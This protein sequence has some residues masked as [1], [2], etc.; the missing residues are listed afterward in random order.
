MQRSR[1]G[2]AAGRPANRSGTVSS[3]RHPGARRVVRTAIGRFAA[4]A[5]PAVDRN[6]EY[7]GALSSNMRVALLL[8]SALIAS[9]AGREVA[10]TIDD[11]PR[12]G[13]HGPS[14]LAGIRAMTERLLKPFHDQ[15]IPL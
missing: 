9:A 6:K 13:D 12:G 4:P 11:L 3:R 1:P 8:L 15:K 2:D 7:L 14:S 5:R 10:I